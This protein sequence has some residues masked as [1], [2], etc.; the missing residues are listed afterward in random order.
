M[1][2]DGKTDAKRRRGGEKG[3]AAALRCSPTLLNLYR[4]TPI[5]TAIA[6]AVL[7][8]A[9]LA[10]F[11]FNLGDSSSTNLYEATSY[12]VN[13]LTPTVFSSG[14]GAEDARDIVM[15]MNTTSVQFHAL[16]SLFDDDA[17]QF[18][19]KG[20]KHMPTSEYE[21]DTI[22]S[23]MQAKPQTKPS[24][25]FMMV[26]GPQSFM[27]RNTSKQTESWWESGAG[28]K[29]YHI[30]RPIM[31]LDMV[32]QDWQHAWGQMDELWA[33][34]HFH[35]KVLQASGLTNVHVVPEVVH[36]GDFD[37]VTDV[38]LKRIRRRIPSARFVFLSVLGW[39]GRKG[40]EVLLRAFHEA[41]PPQDEL[42]AEEQVILLLKANP[43]EITPGNDVLPLHAL[44]AAILGVEQLPK[45][46][47]F[48]EGEHDDTQLPRAEYAALHRLAD[49]FVLP[50]RGE[51]WCRPCVEAMACGKPMIA[52]HW[53]AMQDYMTEENSYPLAYDLEPVPTRFTASTDE[54]VSLGKFEYMKWARPDQA[55]L[56]ELM[57]L[58]AQDTDAQRAKNREVGEAGRATVE[59]RFTREAVAPMVRRRLDEIS[60]AVAGGGGGGSGGS[61]EKG[62]G[63]EVD[64]TAKGVAE[65]EALYDRVYAGKEA[66][67]F[68]NQAT[69]KLEH[70][71]TAKGTKLAQQKVDRNIHCTLILSYSHALIPS[72]SHTLIL[73]YS[74]TLILSYSHTRILS[75]S[76]RFHSFTLSSLEH[77]P[78]TLQ[79]KEDILGIIQTALSK[80]RCSTGQSIQR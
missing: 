12:D 10:T 11:S 26:W 72:Y 70:M 9:G 28:I 67:H 51:G 22:E 49:A 73:S 74:H 33:P 34:T 5:S 35:Q 8:C 39:D 75:H 77:T 69:E 80:V 64:L 13:F 29:H 42:P 17:R 31:E 30:G 6:V 47:V 50:S 16:K 20:S 3:V 63:A 1:K 2:K 59:A 24:M 25:R 44:A 45:N 48:Y 43:R 58:T 21:W 62:T 60:A 27:M 32:P 54:Y 65:K 53:S 38:D 7:L 37:G 56:V 4:S 52:T 14:G 76:H 36:V 46:I 71:K 19:G 41:F 66:Q 23:I 79:T 55:R 40:Y 15:M 78:H 57:R 68:L 61:G 18:F